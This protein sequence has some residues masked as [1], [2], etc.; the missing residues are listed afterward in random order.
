MVSVPE[1]ERFL[2]HCRKLLA[3]TRQ[4]DNVI[5]RENFLIFKP[6]AFSVNLYQSKW[7]KK[8]CQISGCYPQ[9]LKKWK[10]FRF[11]HGSKLLVTI[12]NHLPCGDRTFLRITTLP[13]SGNRC[14][15]RGPGESL[16][17][18]RTLIKLHL[19]RETRRLHLPG[20][21]ASFSAGLKRPRAAAS[22]G[23]GHPAPQLR[24]PRAGG[25]GHAV[26]ACKPGLDNERTTTYCGPKSPDDVRC[27]ASPE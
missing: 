26:R 6:N 19:L 7:K 2:R 14:V 27:L 8:I 25:A 23:A 15:C 22:A 21:V 4:K 17:P 16:L 10:S 18:L 1:S 9:A 24:G 13:L 3:K 20:S 11:S 12:E 5:N